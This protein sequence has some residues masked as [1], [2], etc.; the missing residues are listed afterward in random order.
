MG[1]VKVALLSSNF[2]PEIHAGTEMVVVALAHALSRLGLEPVVVTSSEKVHSGEDLRREVY[3]GIPV[4]RVWKHLDEWDQHRL[5]RPRLTSIVE[6]VLADEKPDVLHVHSFSQLGAGITQSAR[7]MGI[8]TVMTFHDVW[9][10]CPRF[11]R[12]P[13]PGHGIVCPR[14]D[15]REVCV[16]C[17]NLELRHPDIAL[18]RRA[19]HG[20]DASVRREV[21]AAQQLTAPTM[22]AARMVQEN[23]PCPRP[24]EVVGHGLLRP[25]PATERATSPQPT[26]RLRIGTYGNIVEPKGVLE[27]VQSV[28]GIDCELHLAGA[29]LDPAF[30]RTVRDLC[31]ELGVELHYHGAYHPGIPHPALRLHLAVFPSKCQETYGLVVDEALARGV[32]AVVSDNG[33]LVERAA[34]GG[35]VVSSLP[36][37]RAT[38]HHVAGDRERL[39]QLRA[40]VP[41][42]LGSIDGAARRYVELYESTRSPR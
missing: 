33:A 5:D 30:E 2:P 19:V 20:R 38:L 40:S 16:H 1:V 8:G 13:P 7:R 29:F 24:I 39:A 31:T 18:V 10:T 9:V 6:R 25:L 37:L 12:V 35:V 36:N 32:P 17:C 4:A 21:E 11:F 23:L 15:E 28:A 27:L 42:D 14:G 41:V 22:T 3:E 34:H 26:E